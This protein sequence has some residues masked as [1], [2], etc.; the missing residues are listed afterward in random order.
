MQPN[1][2]WHHIDILYTF[3]NICFMFAKAFI[4]IGPLF[5]TFSVR[6]NIHGSTIHLFFPK[7]IIHKSG[8]V[9]GG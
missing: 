7:I 6:F 3:N 4:F 9:V 1:K 5:A 8:S 2:R